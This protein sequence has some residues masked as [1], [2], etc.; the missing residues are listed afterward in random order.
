[1]FEFNLNCPQVLLK[2][3]LCSVSYWSVEFWLHFPQ[4]NQDSFVSELNQLE[5]LFQVCTATPL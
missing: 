4:S 5:L 2:H 1:M 3:L